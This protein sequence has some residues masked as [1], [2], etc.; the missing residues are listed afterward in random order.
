MNRRKG[1]WLR[2]SAHI[3]LHGLAA[4]GAAVADLATML[5]LKFA[6]DF[7]QVITPTVVHK[8]TPNMC[9]RLVTDHFCYGFEVL[10]IFAY[11]WKWIRFNI[12]SERKKKSAIQTTD[13]AVT[14]HSKQEFLIGPA[15]V[16]LVETLWWT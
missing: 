15:V 4:G 13:R 10:A 11:P 16:D 14:L 5:L 9:L 6:E 2:K 7:I 3:F 1:D 12:R 8:E